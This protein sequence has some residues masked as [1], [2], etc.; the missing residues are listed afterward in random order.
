VQS[1]AV[2]IA[3]TA[4]MRSWPDELPDLWCKLSLSESRPWWDLL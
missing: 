4:R 1:A 3:G 2:T